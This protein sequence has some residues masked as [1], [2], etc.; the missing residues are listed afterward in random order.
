MGREDK[1]MNKTVDNV[2]RMK[3]WLGYWR[4]SLI[5]AESSQG[6]LS[7]KDLGRMIA[8]DPTVYKKGLLPSNSPELKKL[9]DGE[10]ESV[11]MIRA[12]L[13][14]AIYKPRLEHGQK[15]SA[16]FPDVITPLV[17]G[18]WVVR[19]GRF[20]PAVA[21]N[22]PRDLLQPQADDCF[23]LAHVAEQDKFLN[24]K[25]VQV[26]SESEALSL[27]EANSDQ[28]R[29]EI[30]DAYYIVTHQLFEKLNLVDLLGNSFDSLGEA[31]LVKVDPLDNPA[32]HIIGLYDWLA[33][34][35]T[36]LPL[37]QS[38]AL[39][40]T[41]QHQPCVDPIKSMATRLGH[42]NTQ[43]PLALAQ[44]DALAQA[45][46]MQDGE[47]L[48]INGPPG[49]G[50][51]TFVLSV[52]ASLWV[53]AA[54]E[55]TEPPL[56]IAASTNNQ[57]VTNVLEAFAEGFEDS[58]KGFG[59]RW[60]PDIDSFGGY[61]PSKSREAEAAQRYQTASFYRETESAEYIERAEKTFLA[62]AQR[63]LGDAALTQV[64]VVKAQ[65]HKH[66][67]NTQEQL[68][69]LQRSWAESQRSKKQWRALVG[70]ATYKEVWGR[71]HNRL[72]AMQ[73]DTAN[74]EADLQH[75]QR[76]CADES[77]FLILLSV[78]PPVARKRRLKKALFIEENFC[79]VSKALLSKN[80]ELD[81]SLPETILTEHLAQQR[82]KVAMQEQQLNSLR[83]IIA[84]GQSAQRSLTEAWSALATDPVSTVPD[85]F[86]EF[87]QALD[88]TLRFK[89]FQLAVHYWEAR[90]LEDCTKQ[91]KELA[92]Q[93]RKNREKT[94]LKS[95]LPRWRRRM[96]LTPCIVSTLHSLPAHMTHQ[97]FEAKG[98]YRNEYLINEIDL[99]I[100]DE[101]GQVAPDVAGASM[102]LAKRVLAIGDVQQIKPVANLSPTVDVGNMAQQGLIT[103]ID[104]YKRLLLEGR[105]VV[106]GSV[107][108]I[109]QSA[110]RYQYLAKAEPGMFL[111]EHRR[112]LNSIISYCN[113]LCYQG[114]LQPLRNTAAVDSELP[115]FA[116]VHVDGRVES[117]VS[118][119]R[120]NRLEAITIAQWLS[121]QRT[122]LER[123]HK[124]PLEKIVGVVTPFKAQAQLIQQECMALGIKVG[125]GDEA[126]TIGTVHALQG[127]ERAI[128]VFSSVYSRHDDGPFIDQDPALL[129]VAVSRAKDSFIVFGD[130]DV[131]GA[132]ALGTPRHLLGQ[133]LFENESNALQFTSKTAR[134]DLLK[135][136]ET[137]QI[138]SNAQ[139][140]DNCL[141][142][143]LAQAQHRVVIVSPWV[144]L[145]RLEETG[146]LTKLQHAVKNNI[147]VSLYTD[148]HFNTTTANQR[149]EKKLKAFDHC[150]T[151]LAE[152]GLI[153]HVVKQVHSKIILVDDSVLCVGSY[154]WASAARE[155]PYK[156]METSILYSGSLKEEI[157]TQLKALNARRC[158]TY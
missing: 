30:W 105:S 66:L 17:C 39:E 18:L 65:L 121:E 43:Y 64:A 142:R 67:V 132:A 35:K 61:F 109:A 91:S 26:C 93:E 89:L 87:D 136:L 97:V 119:S 23:T 34:C 19:D 36:A 112:C 32:R 122:R 55:E 20:L 77:L 78:L 98:Q 128:V 116:Y 45:V 59:G 51:T 74:T 126:M 129:N 153:V 62:H 95:V 21:P 1:V 52:V 3:Q 7:Q 154:N 27:L 15:K 118:G 106:D 90:W 76:F 155:G 86:D 145:E 38:Y 37:L 10:P 72:C 57:A 8:I 150:C 47:V 113:D 152:H 71:E 156:N 134:P 16:L 46:A 100:I 69:A 130:M 70:A 141:Q 127:A 148:E 125:S 108:R 144:K 157:D 147:E 96:K 13:R 5:D 85:A 54:L 117:P 9:F 42:A 114:L 40:N 63:V 44:R 137:P 33:D 158:K 79:S 103:S 25:E 29:A 60:L 14:P 133:Y 82:K 53:K 83:G 99:L 124:Q 146:L 11:Q 115:P 28:Q 4:N 102:A 151:T 143:I 123:V 110:S 80:N 2:P 12:V 84:Q 131:I 149:D 50:K 120:I 48:A 107:M 75:W 22:I 92:E 6:A 138:I 58:A 31:R 111:R 68:A 56:I 81:Q 24:T 104:E 140:H 139:E 88:M 41:D 101:A 135:G 49:T 94:G 73:E